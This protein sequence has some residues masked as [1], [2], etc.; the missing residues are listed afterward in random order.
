VLIEAA[1]IIGSRRGKAHSRLPQNV[2]TVWN[3]VG[4]WYLWYSYLEINPVEVTVQTGSHTKHLGPEEKMKGHSLKVVLR[5]Y[6]R[7]DFYG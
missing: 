1:L 7:I 4:L 6:F 2:R 5:K 3:R